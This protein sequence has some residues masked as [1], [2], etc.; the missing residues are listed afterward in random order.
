MTYPILDCIHQYIYEDICTLA[1]ADLSWEKLKNKTVLITGANGFI[2]YYL[3]TALLIRNDLYKD[4]ITVLALVRNQK[5]AEKRFG[6][7]LNRDDIKLIVQDVCDDI[8][9]TD[10]ADYVIHSASQASAYFF[11]HD[12]VGTIDANL[13]GTYKVLE[14]SRK[15]HAV[16]LFVSSLKVYGDLH[17]GKAKISE[18]DIGY[19]DP[20]NY[21]NCYA[22][23]KRASETLCASFHQQYGMSIKIARPSYIYG[24]SSLDDDRVWAQ[25]IAN[26]VRNEN[27][28]LKSAGTPYRSFCYVTDTA[29]AL[30]KILLDGKDIYP[31]NISS[32]DSNVTIRNFAKTAVEAFPERHLSL[33]FANKEDEIEKTI[34]IM[35]KTPEILDSTRLNEL[36]WTAKVSLTEGIQRAVK[37]V[38]LQS[39]SSS[40]NP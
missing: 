24:A 17:T 29:V 9:I 23:G 40:P 21:K 2:A 36:G 22:Q 31:Y 33:S 5:K 1:T 3:T 13:T 15:C 8:T 26:I 19:L 32:E 12:P 27:I 39:G 38:E 4:N 20:T 7:I 10:K 16:T 6:D 11:E 25:F 34:S 28:L 18:T 35:D 37:I 30:L 14:Y